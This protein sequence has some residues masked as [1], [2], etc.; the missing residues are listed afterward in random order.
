VHTRKASRAARILAASVSL[1]VLFALALTTASPEAFAQNA[2][3]EAVAK[4]LQKKAMEEDYLATEFAKAQDKLEKALAAC[5][6]DKCAAPIRAG[7]RRDLGVVQ[8][9]G[10][11]D[12][13]KG[14]GNFVEA[15]K[16]DPAIALDPD[17]KT[18]DLD[19]AFAEA[20]KRAAGGAAAPVGDGSQPSGDFAHTPAAEQQIRTPIPVYVEYS[21]EEQLAKVIARYKGFG[22]TE[23]KTVELKKMGDKGWG[24]LLPCADVQQG[25]TLYYI[26]GFNP[27]ND[28]VATGGD[29]NNAY[30]VPVKREK[31]AEAPHLPN[32]PAP[33]Q[34]ADTG[35]CPPNFPGCKKAGAGPAAGPAEPTGKDGGE[36]CEEDGECRS[37]ECKENKCTEPEG[38]KQAPKVWVGIAVGFDYTLVPSADDV[39]KLLPTNQ[40]QEPVNQQNYY[41]TESGGADYP[42]RL[43]G[44]GDVV[45]PGRGDNNAIVVGTS[46]KVSGGGAFGNIRVMASLD[47]ALNLNLLLGARLGYVINTYPGQAAKD[48]GKTFPPIHLELR[49]TYL[50]GKDGLLQK[51]APYGMIG[52]GI[53]TF[54]TAVKVSVVEQVANVKTARDVDAWQLSGPAFMTFG[55]GARIG[56]SHR[57]ALMAGLRVNLAFGNAF[58]P[59]AGPDVGVV[60][61]F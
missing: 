32:Q 28:P 19:A 35:D 27:Q 45:P 58:A 10:Q 44:P 2:K 46:D 3:V 24:G 8:I 22:M 40:N 48:D 36:F 51:V 14:I 42:Y 37:K 31:V 25:T 7:L 34:C 43:A 23:W 11:I 1:G 49:G 61:G 39:C 26:Q 52:A 33:P 54:D 20:K 21:G 5:G 55:G 60:F 12:K 38:Q 13:E 50:F 57:A 53:S 18:K 15:I 29:R 17:L 16:L 30:K 4:A 59:S 9:G 41:C 6:T 47:Y 56:F